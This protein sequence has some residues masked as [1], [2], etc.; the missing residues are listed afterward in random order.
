[1][2]F[3]KGQSGNPGGRPKVMGDVQELARQHAP[4]V[5]PTVMLARGIELLRPVPVDRLH[6]AD[7]R[8]HHRTIVFGSLRDSA[9]RH[10]FHVMPGLGDD[11]AEVSDSLA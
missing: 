4:R 3:R 5:A 9:R 11:L 7:A 10:L 1:L 6:H 8:E 2:K